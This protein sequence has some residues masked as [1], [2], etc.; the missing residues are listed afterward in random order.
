MESSKIVLRFLL[1]I[2][3]FIIIVANSAII[4]PKLKES[5]EKH[6]QEHLVRHLE[7]LSSEE[8]S[9]L[10]NDIKRVDLDFVSNV[11]LDRLA[12]CK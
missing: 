6:G 11:T 4:D 8:A 1:L 2:V 3:S 5:L 10:L 7:T 12:T 9:H